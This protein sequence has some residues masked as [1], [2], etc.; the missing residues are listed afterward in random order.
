MCIPPLRAA[1]TSPWRESQQNTI[2]LPDDEVD[3]WVKAVQVLMGETVLPDGEPIEV[4]DLTGNPIEYRP[5]GSHQQM[6]DWGFPD[7]TSTQFKAL[8]D[9]FALADKYLWAELREQCLEGILQFPIG[10][11]AFAMLVTLPQELYIFPEGS[12]RRDKY[13]YGSLHTLMQKAMYY[14]SVRYE[15]CHDR[16][17]NFTSHLDLLEQRSR[18]Y[19]PLDD[20]M[21]ANMSPQAWAVYKG[22][23]QNRTDNNLGMRLDVD[24]RRWECGNGREGV[25]VNSWNIFEAVDYCFG[26][27]AILTRP[28]G[29]G[30]EAEILWYKEKF[31]RLF[32]NRPFSEAKSGD[33]IIRI[34]FGVPDSSETPD[35][36]FVSGLNTRTH[37]EGWFPRSWVRLLEERPKEYCNGSSCGK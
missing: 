22:L 24:A 34:R 14:H 20:F 31:S 16:A 29:E 12:E 8:V 2:A 36:D 6:G 17:F 19:D 1:L 28:Y 5:G 33:I 7:A 25:I 10:P 4:F 13:G 18:M 26:Q 23:A 32:P 11:A 9:L 21:R 15:D 30:K 35:P 27:E 3:T 37:E